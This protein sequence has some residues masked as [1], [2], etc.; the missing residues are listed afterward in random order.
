[1]HESGGTGVDLFRAYGISDATL[2]MCRSKFGGMEMP[3]AIRLK[4]LELENAE[5]Q[6]MLPQE[7]PDVGAQK[8]V[9][10]KRFLQ[11]LAKTFFREQIRRITFLK[12]AI[13]QFLI[14]SHS[15]PCIA[16]IWLQA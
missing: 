1:M 12:E 13:Q 5:L 6:K 2:Y 10:G 7:M 4:V 11:I 3:D 8:E 16:R 9:L 15:T 14:D